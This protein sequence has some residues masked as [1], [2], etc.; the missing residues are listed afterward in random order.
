MTA[1]VLSLVRKHL[2]L[3]LDEISGER[4]GLR[5]YGKGRKF[6]F[7][8]PP[9]AEPAAFAGFIDDLSRK[10][11]ASGPMI[12]AGPLC[13]EWKKTGEAQ[14]KKNGNFIFIPIQCQPTM[15]G[16][17]YL[18][19]PFPHYTN[20]DLEYCLAL[21]RPLCWV[22][23]NYMQPVRLSCDHDFSFK[24]PV[25]GDNTEFRKILS[26]IETIRMS[27]APVFII[28]ESG[29]GKELVARTIHMTSGRQKFPFIAFNC[30]AIPDLLLESELF[31]YT[32]GAF[33]G[34]TKD[35][36]GLIEEAEK[37]TFFLDEIGDLSPHLQ[38][39]LLRV[40]QEKELRRIGE[41]KVRKVD[42]RFLSATNM[43]IEEEMHRGRFREDLYY[44]LKVIAIE[45]PPLRQRKD[46]IPL[47]IEH[48]LEKYCQETSPGK[49]FFSP[50]AMELLISYQWPGNIRELENEVRRCLALSDG[51]E[52]IQEDVLS[53]KINPKR[54]IS[55][56]KTYS[57]FEAKAEFERRFLHQ[58]LAR[59]NYN[60]SRA[61]EEIGLSRQGLFKLLKKHQIQV[62]KKN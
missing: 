8:E 27:D 43:D 60:K 20:H 54:Q 23:R 2:R 56:A 57:F 24:M 58:A 33:T 22:L 53:R 38:A 15:R 52:L 45:I 37:G 41:T 12:I 9:G 42:V 4:V 28:G 26:I 47:L 6:L 55:I 19:R 59:F 62:P 44:R 49:V 10:I 7:E 50:R 30:A 18:E 17:L 51:K 13:S 32:R 16:V 25:V 36:P 35:K 39:K 61:A 29:T 3:I 31:G 5:L 11:L 21:S 46:D 48:F 40:I 34:A 14:P 1:P